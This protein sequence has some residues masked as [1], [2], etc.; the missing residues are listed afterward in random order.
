MV[1]IGKKQEEECGSAVGRFKV[2]IL[3]VSFSLSFFYFLKCRN[4]KNGESIGRPN[5]A[6]SF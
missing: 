5:D 6:V 1:S 2:V 3:C 4:L